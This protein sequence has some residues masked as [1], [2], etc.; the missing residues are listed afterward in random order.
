MTQHI[1]FIGGGNMALAMASGL[2]Q[3]GHPA[4]QITVADPSPERRTLASQLGELN[5]VADNIAAAASADAV[6]LAVKPHLIEPVCTALS[7]TIGASGALVM[8]VAAGI[9]IDAIGAA[10]GGHARIARIMP[11]TPALVGRGASGVYASD[12]VSKEDRDTVDHLLSACG[13]VVWVQSE[14]RLHDITAISGS[15]PAYFF[16]FMEYLKDQALALGLSDEDAAKLVRQTAAG[17]AAMTQETDVSLAE[18]RRRVTSP[19]GTTEAAIGQFM[20][21]NLNGL[22]ERA[23]AA[24]RKRSVELAEPNGDQ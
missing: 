3:A 12:A 7:A 9:T 14:D 20:H 1:C 19:G 5:V 22:V 10:L 13:M 2:L 21:D 16:L 4:N 23:V 6:I 11:N 24:A 15:G 18:L 17:A 8:S